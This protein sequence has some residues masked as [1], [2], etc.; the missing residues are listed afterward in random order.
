M[1]LPCFSK[2]KVKKCFIC[3]KQILT[4]NHI[5][6][7]RCN[8]HFHNICYTQNQ[9]DNYIRCPHCKCIGAI[10]IVK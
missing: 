4:E 5:I 8:T 3:S 10:N 2:K 6:C 1:C 7:F 9:P